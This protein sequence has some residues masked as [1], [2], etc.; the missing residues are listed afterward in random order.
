[1]VVEA[2]AD[3]ASSVA[4]SAGWD[5]SAG[6]HTATPAHEIDR[7]RRHFLPE[8]FVDFVFL[9]TVGFAGD[10]FA[11]KALSQFAQNFGLVP[12]LTIGPLMVVLLLETRPR[13]DAPA[14]LTG[15]E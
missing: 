13:A 3:I 7:N 8:R 4:E 6:E 2:G 10:F 9:A 14:A 1:M 15:M 11:P 12:V 5:Q